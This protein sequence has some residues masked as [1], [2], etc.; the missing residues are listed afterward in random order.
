MDRLTFLEYENARLI[1]ENDL[2]RKV[3]KL[4]VHVLSNLPVRVLSFV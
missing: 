1:K 2:L 4:L 3:C